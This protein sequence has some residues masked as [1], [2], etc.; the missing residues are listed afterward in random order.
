MTKGW[1]RLQAVAAA[2]SAGEGL[3]LT[4]LPLLAVSIT[5]DPR[6]VSMVN[7]VGQS[8]WL[9]FSLVAGVVID[10]VRR[11][12]VLAWAFAV[13]ACAALVLA[14]AGAAGLLSLPLLLVVAFVVASGQVLGDGA[15]AALVPEVAPR[16]RLESANARMMVIERGVVQFVVPPVAGLLMAFGTGAPAWLAVLTAAVAFGLARSVPCTAVAASTTHPLRDIA[17][18]LKYLVSTRLLRSITIAVAMGSFASSA[19]IA[20]FVLYATQILQVGSVGYGMLLACGAVGWVGSSFV[21]QRVVARLGY[22]WSMRIAQSCAALWY[23]LL[24]V[25]PPWPALVGVL[26]VLLPAT[27]LGWNVCSQS[28]RQRFTPPHLLGR[29]LTSHRMLAWGPTPLGALT[30]GLVAAEWGL[31]AV[32]LVASAIFALSVSLLWRPV[33][34]AAFRAAEAQASEWDDTRARSV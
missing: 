19:W 23:L 26:L 30:G 14:V 21:I 2:G 16:D 15:A 5:T 20:M 29:V 27:A 22:A 1:G 34:P 6:E 10:R 32:F 28:S 9:L 31:R 24:A 3:L 17:E 8:P 33:S 18:G 7:V 12:T 13:Q 11:A 25:V 4:V